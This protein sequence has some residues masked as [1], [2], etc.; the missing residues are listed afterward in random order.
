MLLRQ[1][2]IEASMIFIL[3]PIIAARI[4]NWDSIKEDIK[5]TD[6]WEQMDFQWLRRLGRKLNPVLEI[7]R[8]NAGQKLNI[9]FT[10]V[11]GLLFTVSGI[12]IWQSPRF[13]QWVSENAVFLHDW[14]TWLVLAVWLG[15][16][17]LSVFHP[18]TRE[19]LR[20]MTLGWVKGSW[21]KKHHRR[22][23]TEVMEWAKASGKK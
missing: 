16:V 6:Q 14:L 15:H 8:F 7:G 2:H 21:A 4:G 19:S 23:Y 9:I 20:R 17:Y 22:W 10:L 5:Q 12:I 13:P 1:L 18:S 11:A 3:G